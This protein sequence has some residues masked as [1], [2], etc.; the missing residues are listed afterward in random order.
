MTQTKSTLIVG[1]LVGMVAIAII[2]VVLL[3][4]SLKPVAEAE[5]T[6]PEGMGYCDVIGEMAETY[7]QFANDGIP[8]D[9]VLE[10]IESRKGNLPDDEL[11]IHKVIA[12]SAYNVPRHVT[13]R[14]FRLN[15]ELE[16]HNSR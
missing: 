8:L 11:D 3:T 1:G 15:W 13:S 12:F 16:C 6:L 2:G 7:L 9:R 10:V 14:Q 5:D 4:G